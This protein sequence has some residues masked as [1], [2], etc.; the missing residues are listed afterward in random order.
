ML[1]RVES[2]IAASATRTA[3]RDPAVV[4]AAHTAPARASAGGL[5]P[6]SMRLFAGRVE[7]ILLMRCGNAGCHGGAGAGAFHLKNPSR[8]ATTTRQNLAAALAFVGDGG[9]WSSPLLSACV[10]RPDRR[11][12]TPFRV[13]GGPASRAALAAWVARIAAE[14]PD[15]AA[16][17]PDLAAERP[18]LAARQAPP[19][20]RQA[21]EKTLGES[22]GAAPSA[23]PI[24]PDVF[25]PAE[26]NRTFAAPA[27]R[28][29]APRPVS[30]PSGPSSAAPFAP[31]AAPAADVAPF[32]P[33]P[34]LS[35]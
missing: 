24:Q 22:T 17:R 3:R 2:V 1:R 4:Q 5:S 6:E 10:D 16:E 29:V 12:R 18:D 31:P 25:D 11:G 23:R 15:L 13:Q 21:G 9:G 27:P 35:E 34:E 14:R 8:S 7:R 28:P 30:L 19:A 32:A 33:A 20:L 26:F